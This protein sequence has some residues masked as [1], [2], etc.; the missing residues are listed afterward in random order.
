M[1]K[2]G[3]ILPYIFKE[4]EIEE[5]VKLKYLRKNWTNIFDYPISNHTFPRDLKDGILTVAVNCHTWLNELILRKNEFLDRFRQFGIKSVEFRYGRVPKKTKINNKEKTV[6]LSSSEEEWI[7]GI[8]SN[9]KDSEI[10]D[11]IERALK[12][13]VLFNKKQQ[14]VK[15]A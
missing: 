6:S 2:I 8:V 10:R 15:N 13:F 5:A 9:F 14:G 7:R 3:S 1:Q 11:S 4:L 12:N